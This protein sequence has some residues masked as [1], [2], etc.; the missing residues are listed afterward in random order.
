VV[1]KTLDVPLPIH[2]KQIIRYVMGRPLDFDPGTKYV[3]SNFG[4]CLLGRVIEAVSGRSYGD[5]V[6][7]QILRPL[8]FKH[9]QLG[10]NLYRDRAPNEVTYYDSKNREGRAVVGPRIGQEVPIPYGVENIENMD[11][12]GGW[13]AST[14]DLLR[15]ATALDNPKQC[16]IFKEQTIRTMLA[17]PAGKIGHRP[18]G[19]PKDVY[20]ACGWQV[21]PAGSGRYTKWHTGMLSGTST[22]LVCRDDGIDWAVLFNSDAT[23]DGKQFAGLIDPLLHRPADEITSWP[24]VDLFSRF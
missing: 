20:Y 21:R 7:Q 10:K 19:E 5:F 23:K 24:D 22:L 11:G 2:P 4:Y 6:T 13:I 14:V 15:F 9:M 16:P 8:G 12:N 3:Y 18:N 17:P 1:A